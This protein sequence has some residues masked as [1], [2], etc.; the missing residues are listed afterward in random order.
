MGKASQR[1]EENKI[2]D[3]VPFTATRDFRNSRI[4]LGYDLVEIRF[5]IETKVESAKFIII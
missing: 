1:R 2:Q 4:T 5:Y 3:N